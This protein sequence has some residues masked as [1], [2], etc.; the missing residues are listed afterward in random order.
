[1]SVSDDG[2]TATLQRGGKRL[3]V[4]ILEC[5]LLSYLLQHLRGHDP[6][7][8]VRRVWWDILLPRVTMFA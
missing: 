6:D 1:V 4:G 8:E 5:G 2:T 3:Q 7:H